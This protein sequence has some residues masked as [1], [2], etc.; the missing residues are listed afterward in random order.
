MAMEHAD[1]LE[2][3][4]IAAAEP[5]GLER[6][7]AGDTPE[8][9]L[10]AGHLAGC[11]SCADA[12]R[13][14][15]H[16]AALARATI[17]ELPDPAMRE[18][19][20]AYVRELGRDRS[21]AATALGGPSP[22]LAALDVA[23]ATPD[24]VAPPSIVSIGSGRSSRRRPWLI[25]GL[26]AAVVVAAVLG[27]AAGGALRPASGS[28]DEVAH[29]VGVIQA[30]MRI[31]ARPDVVR[32]ALAPPDGSMAAGTVLYSPGSGELAMIVT[33]LAPAPD[34][35]TYSCWIES[36]GTKRKIGVV[37]AD[38]GSGSWAGP[39]KGL[40]GLAPGSTF[41]VSL[42]PGGGQPSTPVLTGS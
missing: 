35:S 21:G 29:A 34:G 10:V 3:I 36:N 20:L 13:R 18:R 24:A 6:L 28:P 9:S 37:Y 42:V 11:P 22:S 7:A 15:T 31:A 39:V 25:A 26:A 2:L 1:A 5:F 27:F 38:N 12:L 30:T 17:R 41:G 23:S 14:T 4:E 19:T 16:T 40:D 33:G 32:V 8:S